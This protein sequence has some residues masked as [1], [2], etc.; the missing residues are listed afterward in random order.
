MHHYRV[1]HEANIW[2]VEH[3]F[4]S[5]TSVEGYIQSIVSDGEWGQFYSDQLILADGL[6]AMSRLDNFCR[7]KYLYSSLQNEA[8]DIF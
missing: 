5:S 4:A 7:E 1:C 6:L 2:A 3:E 8:N